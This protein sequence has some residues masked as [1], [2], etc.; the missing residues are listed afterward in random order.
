MKV[1]LK[2]VIAFESLGFAL[3]CLMFYGCSTTNRVY[4]DTDI[5]YGKKSFSLKYYV[6]DRNR[7]S[8]LYDFHQTIIKEIK[9]NNETTYK[10]F[11]VLTLSA[12][13]FKLDEKVFLIINNEVFSMDIEKIEF[14]NI[15]SVSENTTDISTSDSTSVSVVTGYSENNSKIVKFTYKIPDEVISKIKNS[16]QLLIRYYSGPHIITVKPKPLSFI[17]IQ[18]LIN[19]K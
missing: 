2:K 15:K 18:Q 4:S 19:S 11:D 1:W 16:N 6:K 10:A 3:I 7:R 9:N 14:D 8:P 12:S 5:V 13:S 17:K